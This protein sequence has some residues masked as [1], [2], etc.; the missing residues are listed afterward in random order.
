MSQTGET[1][2][3]PRPTLPR[4][5]GVPELASW[6]KVIGATM[7][8][9]AA[10]VLAIAL[11]AVKASDRLSVLASGSLFAVASL[12]AG[13]IFGFLFGVPRT[14]TSDGSTPTGGQSSSL[15]QANTNLEQISDW[16]TKIIVG[17]TLVQL[18]TIRSGAQ[19]LFNSM[20]PSLGSKPG[21]AAVA[22]SI[23]VFF[24][25]V[26]FISGW[27]MTR[28]FLGRAMSDADVYMVAAAA[29]ESRGDTAG[30]EHLRQQAF[31]ILR[32]PG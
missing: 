21:G 25:G 12:A 10:G 15:I 14:R 1:K 13:A 18:G 16:L 32:S 28:L 24:A 26:G 19:R 4:T 30:A 17:V 2:P 27:L 5:A 9:F 8:A 7:L 20:A 3:T 22:G 6:R 31:A 29:A 23:V 11:Y